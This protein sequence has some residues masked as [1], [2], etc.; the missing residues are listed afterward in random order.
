M[1]GCG[2]RR[3]LKITP[4]GVRRSS[5]ALGSPADGYGRRTLVARAGAGWIAAAQDV[6]TSRRV[7][8]REMRS[9]RGR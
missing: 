2:E 9:W 3:T 1:S 4:A 5:L 8:T 6:K 7:R